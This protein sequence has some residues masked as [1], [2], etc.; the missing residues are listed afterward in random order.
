VVGGAVAAA[1]RS[2]P[3]PALTGRGGGGGADAACAGIGVSV[4]FK[5]LRKVVFDEAGVVV[6]EPAETGIEGADEDPGEPRVSEGGADALPLLG[7]VAG[8]GC[9]DSLLLGFSLLLPNRLLTLPT[10]DFSVLLSS[11]ASPAPKYP[12]SAVSFEEPVSC[13]VCAYRANS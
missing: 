3:A 7:V 5:L 13:R 10:L 1:G 6:V 11:A 12:I 2:E 4:L 9:C 8:E